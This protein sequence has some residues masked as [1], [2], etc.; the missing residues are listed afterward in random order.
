MSI[1]KQVTIG[2]LTHKDIGKEISFKTEIASVI[3]EFRGTLGGIDRNMV[4]LK[5]A[6]F[7]KTPSSPWTPTAQKN[8]ELSLTEHTSITVLKKEM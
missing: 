8:P 3:A 7:R 4:T 5:N 2:E 6:Q 1:E